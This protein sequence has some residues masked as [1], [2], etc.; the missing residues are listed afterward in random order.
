MGGWINVHSKLSDRKM[1]ISD[2]Q[3]Q[4]SMTKIVRIFLIFFF[5]EEYQ[6]RGCFLL[7][8]FFEN[9]DF[10]STLVSKNIPPKASIVMD[11]HGTTCDV[12]CYGE[13]GQPG[14]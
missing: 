4:F 2:F 7:L 10:E 12:G 13:K 8:T 11:S 1:P 5:I 14:V 3:S 6:P 9:F